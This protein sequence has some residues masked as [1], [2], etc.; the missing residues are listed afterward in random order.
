MCLISWVYSKFD[1]EVGSCLYD[2]GSSSGGDVI[3]SFNFR[4][5]SLYSPSLCFVRFVTPTNIETA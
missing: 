5:V 2:L 3:K 1:I 4:T